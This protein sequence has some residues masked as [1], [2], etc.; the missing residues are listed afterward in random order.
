LV[1]LFITI[2]MFSDTYLTISNGNVPEERFVTSLTD[3]IIYVYRII[4][5]DFNVEEFG[6]VA[7][8]LCFAL[9]IICTIFNTIVMLNLL[10]VI[11]SESFYNVKSNSA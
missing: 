10:I 2:V 11:I 8:P 1:V 7:V 4:L 6:S 9:F 3:S 5:G